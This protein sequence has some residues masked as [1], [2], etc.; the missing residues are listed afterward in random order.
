MDVAQQFPGSLLGHTHYSC[1]SQPFFRG[2]QQR[3]VCIEI[4]HSF[5]KTLQMIISS[6][7]FFNCRC[8]SLSF[9][10]QGKS[11]VAKT[12]WRGHY[13]LSML[14]HCIKS[15]LLF[16]FCILQ[17]E[18]SLTGGGPGSSPRG[19]G[20]ANCQRGVQETAGVTAEYLHRVLQALWSE[21]EDLAEPG[22]WAPSDFSGAAGCEVPHEVSHK[23]SA[24]ACSFQ[25]IPFF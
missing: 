1:D 24:L 18:P 25:G 15:F 13:N 20:W 16:S 6:F 17:G 10:W 3:I 21:A 12:S 5:N 23:H 14:I 7:F 8:N 2:G 4:I 22:W 9:Q 19:A 11:S